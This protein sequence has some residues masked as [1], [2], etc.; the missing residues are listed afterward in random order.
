[1][2]SPDGMTRLRRGGPTCP[3]RPEPQKM[4]KSDTNS[5]KEVLN[6]SPGSS[7]PRAFS[8]AAISRTK[9]KS[10]GPN[11]L[12]ARGVKVLA[13]VLYPLYQLRFNKALQNSL[14]P[15]LKRGRQDLDGPPQEPSNHHLTHPDPHV[16]L[17]NRPQAPRARL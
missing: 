10:S 1:M 11:G 16:P 17:R 12:D 15:A 7:L 14:P 13:P 9:N 4:T 6:R 5:D 2:T 8:W 3:S